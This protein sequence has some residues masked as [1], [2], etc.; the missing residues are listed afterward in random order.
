MY[1][2]MC[3]CV[4]RARDEYRINRLLLYINVCSC[5]ICALR[6]VCD[7]PVWEYI[8]H[9]C[10]CVYVCTSSC[11]QINF[12]LLCMHVIKFNCV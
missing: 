6:L 11:V 2:W 1:N 5:V 8:T 7:E 3:A 9:V 10:S 12:L 4:L